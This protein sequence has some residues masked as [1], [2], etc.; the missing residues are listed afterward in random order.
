MAN[1]SDVLITCDYDRTLTAPDGSIPERNLEA[2]RFF[3]ENGGAFTVNTGRG[4]AMAKPFLEK[5]PFN[6]PLLLCNGS[7]AYDPW[8]KEFLFAHTIPLDQATLIGQLQEM[9]PHSIVEFQA[10]ERHYTFRENPVW[11]EFNRRNFCPDGYANPG[12]DLGPFIKLCIY[13]NLEESTVAH[14][15]RATPEQQAY[16]DGVEQM[17]RAR[18]DDQLTILRVAPRII[19]IHAKGVN[20]GRAALEL[21]EKLG[22]KILVCIGDEYNDLAMLQAADYAY[23]PAD[24]RIADKFENVCECASGAVADV[25]YKKI[26][27]I[28]N[29]MP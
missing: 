22:K 28:L 10:L 12:D 6:A 7:T 25:I 21:K 29:K 11:K 2:I 13:D 4:M 9:V 3:I 20:K 23:S 26:P 5:V 8:K 19:D 27:E 24:G 18:Y 1:F 17:L 16:F 14:L 15:F